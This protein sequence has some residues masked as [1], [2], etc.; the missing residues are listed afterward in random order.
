MKQKKRRQPKVITCMQSLFGT[1]M[2]EGHL[3]K[4][5]N[6]H[7]MEVHVEMSS[8]SPLV[9]N[10]YILYSRRKKKTAQMSISDA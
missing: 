10:T 8:V 1:L 9:A 3:I 2:L 5:M 6:I 7:L 4:S